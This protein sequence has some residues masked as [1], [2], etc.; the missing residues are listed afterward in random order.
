MDFE[1]DHHD[2]VL[3]SDQPSAVHLRF[4]VPPFLAA[5]P[6]QHITH[7][8]WTR[9]LLRTSDRDKSRLV[10]VVAVKNSSSC[11]IFPQPQTTPVQFSK[12][13]VGSS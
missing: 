5:S 7:L 3:L 6:G 9:A 13:A 8:R 12:G 4:D 1:S 2:Y 11:Y 10:G